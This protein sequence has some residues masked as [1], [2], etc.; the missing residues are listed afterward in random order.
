MLNKLFKSLKKTRNSFNT[1]IHSLNGKKISINDIELL[2]EKL[3][4]S[5]IGYATVENILNV[6]KSAK[7]SN[8]MKKLEEYLFSI[9]PNSLDIK[10]SNFPLV[11]MIVGVNG[12]GKTTSSAKLANFYKTLGYDVTLIGA[13]TYR[14]AA[15]NQL[16]VWADKVNCNFICNEQTSDPS[17]I[18]FDG[19]KSSKANN[20]DVIIIDTAGR[21]HNH[22]NLMEELKKMNNVINTR[23]SEF[24]LKKLITMDANLGQNSIIQ[25]NEF[26]KY[27][28][29]DG[30]ILTKLDGT[31]KGGVV[32][33]IYSELNIPVQFIGYGESLDDLDIFKSEE[34][35]KSFLGISA[36]DNKSKV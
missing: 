34:Y 26:N 13:D 7:E 28:K 3:L 5:D 17:A 11:Y 20:S 16:K 32:F 14:A 23:F 2:E 21:M 36:N 9:L 12:T 4:E 24:S 10:E 15:I 22:E 27:I 31:A 1:L 19:L 18:L 35:V 8:F 6:I 33:P 25:A 30:A 29:I